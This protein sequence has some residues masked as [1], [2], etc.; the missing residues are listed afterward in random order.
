MMDGLPVLLLYSAE[1]IVIV[2][3][4]IEKAKKK[5]MGRSSA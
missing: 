2:N 4:D 1:G 5:E 3:E